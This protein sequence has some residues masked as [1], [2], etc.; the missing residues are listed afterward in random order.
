MK[1][2]NINILILVAVASCVMI[3]GGLGFWQLKRLEE[4]NIFIAKINSNINN[5]PLIIGDKPELYSKIKL[6]GHFLANQDI[7]LYGRKSSAVNN[8]QTKDGYYLVTPFQTDDNKIIITARGW[9]AYND[10][11]KMQS[12]ENAQSEEIIGI[13]LPSE[14][15]QLFV[16]ENDIARNVWFTLDLNQMSGLLKD[17]IED[18][19]LLQMETTH[20]INILMKLSYS[21]LTHIRNDHLEYAIT[22]F[23]LAI[24][25]IVIFIIYIN[26]R[27]EEFKNINKTT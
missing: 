26:K 6:R 9:F 16:P 23:A 4:K 21:K 2:Y 12:I 7:Y 18:F 10:K 1:L 15:K 14:K 13:T 8:S 22:W 25:L 17:K 5:P 11:P 19:Y 27:H 20:P 3:L 24:S